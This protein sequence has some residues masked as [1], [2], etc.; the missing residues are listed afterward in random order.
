MVRNPDVVVLNCDALEL[1]CNTRTQGDS[2][3]SQRPNGSGEVGCERKKSGW[4]REAGSSVSGM[5]DA[6]DASLTVYIELA[7]RLLI[8]ESKVLGR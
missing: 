5:R 1:T 6:D 7:W 4:R 2:W 3:I 8:S